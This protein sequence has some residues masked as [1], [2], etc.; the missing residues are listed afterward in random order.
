MRNATTNLQPGERLICKIQPGRAWFDLIKTILIDA[1]AIVATLY[2]FRALSRSFTDSYIH[3]ENLLGW[4]EFVVMN[5]FLG[6][7]PMLI[8]LALV[9]DF[10]YIFFLELSL[11]DRRIIGRVSGILWARRLELPLDEIASVTVRANRLLVIEGKNGRKTTLLGFGNY[12]GFAR[13]CRQMNL[14]PADYASAPFE[15]SQGR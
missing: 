9:Q 2:L 15:P 12:R 6:I 4:S 5:L 14:M 11:T 1:L 3:P 7:T 13:A 10:A 8:I